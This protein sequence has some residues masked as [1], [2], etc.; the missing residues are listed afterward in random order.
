MI[1]NYVIGRNGLIQ[2]DKIQV[3][4]EIWCY[5]IW[6]KVINKQIINEWIQVESYC[7]HI[8]CP[9]DSAFLL[10]L[11]KQPCISAN[12]LDILKG[13]QPNERKIIPE[14][15]MDGLMIGDGSLRTKTKPYLNIGKKDGDYFKQE[16]GI[17][18]LIVEKQ[19]STHDLG[20]KVKSSIQIDELPYLPIRPIP[21][22]FV[23]ATKPEIC[24]FLK[25]LF[26][27]NGS[28][29]GNRVALRSTC[30]ELILKAQIML[31]SI[32]IA[33]SYSPKEE[34]AVEWENGTYISKKAYDL[35]IV[36][37]R[38]LFT[39]YIGFVQQYK[40]FKLLK[41]ISSV[42][43]TGKTFYDIK[44]K[45]PVTHQDVWIQTD[46]KYNLFWCNGLPV[47]GF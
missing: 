38:D 44:L 5:N 35:T 19:P 46:N 37:D 2:I 1:Y 21:N 36:N 16:C 41:T 27:A 6:N 4:D 14:L 18:H 24:S 17:S 13:P 45:T 39:K 10:N 3:G 43:Q 9:K 22:R 33:S 42:R 30:F 8:C 12:E 47:T 20:W 25:G 15:V 11:R 32:G 7:G 31:G 29:S 26:S 28:I 40:M 34:R 23:T